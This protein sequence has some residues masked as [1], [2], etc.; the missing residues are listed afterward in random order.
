M[1][2]NTSSLLCPRCSIAVEAKTEGWFYRHQVTDFRSYRD[3]ISCESGMNRIPSE[4]NVHICIY[5]E[6]AASAASCSYIHFIPGFSRL[7]SALTQPPQCIVGPAAGPQAPSFSLSLHSI[8]LRPTQ[9]SPRHPT[10][11]LLSGSGAAGSSPGWWC[12]EMSRS[13]LCSNDLVRG[14]I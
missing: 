8:Q 7:R 12:S 9:A 10:H 3:H 6:V 13:T 5:Q 4:A 14:S 2:T 11:W 1:N